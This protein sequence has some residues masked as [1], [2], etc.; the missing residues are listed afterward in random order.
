MVLACVL[1]TYAMAHV[2]QVPGIT[3]ALQLPYFYISYDL[4]LD[5]ILVIVAAV[6]VGSGMYWLLGVP[7]SR[8][9]AP[10]IMEHALL[11]TLTAYLVGSFLQSLDI[12]AGWV[13][14]FAIGATLVLG[15][16]IAE[17]N[18]ADASSPFYSPAAAGLTALGYVAF[19]LFIVGTRLASARLYVFAPAVFLTAGGVA[20]RTLHL[21]HG[22]RWQ[23]VWTLGIAVIVTQFSVGLH[24]WPLTPLQFGLILLAP[25][26]GLTAFA[27]R[28]LAGD[29]SREAAISP[30][31][32]SGLLILAGVLVR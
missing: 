17:L 3:L 9:S 18:V 10:A 11:P 1:I 2:F 5:S 13:M 19:V 30:A 4:G 15:V 27:V 29:Q 21:E 14:G 20:L 12:T 26:Y 8:A 31:V 16:I 7:M 23:P 24:Y 22:T 6:L 32:I 28:R 25:L